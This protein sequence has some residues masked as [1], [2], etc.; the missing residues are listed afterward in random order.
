MKRFCVFL[1]FLFLFF[2]P[3]PGFAQQEREIVT[4]QLPGDAP[5][6]DPTPAQI[7]ESLALFDQCAGSEFSSAHY[8]CQCLAAMFLDLRARS[9]EEPA[10][11]L[12]L[13]ART[14]CVNK[15]GVAGRTYQKCVSWAMTQR[16]DYEAFCACFAN[17]FAE[18]FSGAPT[19]FLAVRERQ[20]TA[21]LS[22]CNIGAMTTER[23]NRQ[24]MIEDLRNKGLYDMLFPGAQDGMLP[25]PEDQPK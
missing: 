3:H 13:K 10:S 14:K 15:P 5:A 6:P 11:R 18:R 7:D 9:P 22:A 17:D 25:P 24:K 4:G 1:A 2:A 8:D 12:I 23:L 16:D 19:E 21:S 20:M